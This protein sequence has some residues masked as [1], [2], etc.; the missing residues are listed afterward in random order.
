MKFL[1]IPILGAVLLAGCAPAPSLMYTPEYQERPQLQQ[2]LFGLDQ[3]LLSDEALNTILT[4]KLVLPE[5]MKVA[6]MRYSGQSSAQ[7]T[8][9]YRYYGWYEEEYLKINQ[10]YID[11]LVQN[12]LISD[13]VMEATP[14]PNLI[15]PQNP[16]ISVLREAAV[17]LQADV[18]VVFD[19]QS[20]IYQK[21]KIFGK[22]E[23][24][25]YSTCEAVMLDV[26]TGLIPFTT[27][28]TRD[29]LAKK[30]DSD[31]NFRETEK[32]AIRTAVLQGLGEIG[33][34]IKT[35]LN[36]VE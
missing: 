4:S 35:F 12:I 5:T 23:A 33:E 36:S 27:I 9:Y 1:L 20:D 24:K 31:A 14:M 10:E 18:L 7:Q 30:S 17:R 21:Y 25:A 28:V 34:Q 32:R 22:D 19:V 6:V 13:R 16:S 26:R 3:A 11:S 2:S 8:R 15:T 29:F